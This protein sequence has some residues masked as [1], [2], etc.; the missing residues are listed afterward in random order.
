MGSDVVRC[1]VVRAPVPPP[2]CPLP[3]PPPLLPAA[4]AWPAPLSLARA[5]TRPPLPPRLRPPDAA[6]DEYVESF[7]PSLMDVIYGWSK[8]ASF[9]E[10]CGMTDIF[11]GSIIRCV[12]VCE[13]HVCASG[14]V[15]L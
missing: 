1:D 11:E 7:R 2:P 15:L 5:H 4:A 14:R 12:C 10:V 8:G 6:A 13:V 9:G 3:V